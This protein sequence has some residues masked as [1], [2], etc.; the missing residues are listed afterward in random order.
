LSALTLIDLTLAANLVLMVVLAG[1][2]NFVS[3]TDNADDRPAWMGTIGFP[4]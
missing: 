3:K 4:A 1:Y 2:D